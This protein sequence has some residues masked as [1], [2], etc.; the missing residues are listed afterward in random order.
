MPHYDNTEESLTIRDI[1]H[2]YSNLAAVLLIE[3]SGQWQF[4]SIL[5]EYILLWG[6]MFCFGLDSGL[7]FKYQS[8]LQTSEFTWKER[9]S[10]KLIPLTHNAFLQRALHSQQW[11][12]NQAPWLT[13]A[14]K[15]GLALH[16]TPSVFNLC[17][18][19]P[20]PSFTW[21]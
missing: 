18:G 12:R 9:L 10:G 1:K 2:L 6:K 3:G 21:A 19:K 20:T 13:I 4:R 14:M 7:I 17:R 11:N 8:H 16:S 5:Q 15:L